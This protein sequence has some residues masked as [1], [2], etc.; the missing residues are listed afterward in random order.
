MTTQL[1]STVPNEIHVPPRGRTFARRCHRAITNTRR[2]KQISSSNSSPPKQKPLLVSSSSSTRMPCHNVM[3]ACK[4][5]AGKVIYGVTQKRTTRPCYPIQEHPAQN[6]R[7]QN[8]SNLRNAREV[9]SSR[10]RHTIASKASSNQ[11]EE[12]QKAA[13]NESMRRRRHSM[14]TSTEHDMRGPIHDTWYYSSNHVLVN[15]ER[16]LRNIPPLRRS[17]ALDELAR[18]MASQL[19]SSDG[20]FSPTIPANCHAGNVIVG[21]SIRHI[22]EQTMNLANSIERANILNPSFTEFGMGTCKASDG[23]LYLVQ[24]FERLDSRLEI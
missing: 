15:R 24:F 16:M 9:I 17:I 3:D 23:Q 6:E 2:K 11:E 12:E 22:H 18:A 7:P 20:G 1:I 19:A 21:Y 10:R 14:M 4:V 5:K 8:D 13:L